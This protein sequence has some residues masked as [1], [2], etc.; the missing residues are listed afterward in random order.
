MYNSKISSKSLKHSVQYGNMPPT[1]NMVNQWPI[2]VPNNNNNLT[3]LTPEQTS[4]EIIWQK[5]AEF[6]KP[7]KNK[8]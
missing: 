4:L 7:Q 3:Y 5:C 8:N 6:C 2:S 1:N